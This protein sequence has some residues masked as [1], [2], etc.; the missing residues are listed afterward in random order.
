[1]LVL[2][3]ADRGK[4]TLCRFLVERAA[5]CGR[6]A[7]LL[8]ADV[9]QKTVGPPACVTAGDR[10]GA[11]LFFV[12]TTNPVRGWRRLIEGTRRLA[13]GLDAE[14]VI[15]N[16]SGLLAGPG[17]R[18]KAAKI[19]AFQP[20]LLIALGD[21]PDLAAIVNDHPAVPA[22]RLS[23]S[24]EARRKT[25]GEKRA[26]RREAFRR[27][28]AGAAVQS[29]DS[30]RVQLEGWEAPL[31]AGLL[32]GLSDAH[33]SRQG[34]GIVA[35]YSGA[36]VEILTPVAKSSIRRITPGSLCL[37]DAFAERSVKPAA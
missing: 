16:T 34:L 29:L 8:D 30:S 26:A 31:P 2:G 3:A 13:Q 9:G 22:L 1:V 27:Y 11:T 5:G 37:N 21:D 7:A 33:D 35:G 4:S 6:S 32:L 10:G 19:E 36:A 14:L 17:R 24:P 23:V 15:A 18:L 25:N 20:N 12:G 28:F